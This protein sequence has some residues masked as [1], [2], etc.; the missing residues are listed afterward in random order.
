MIVESQ[1]SIN[2]WQLAHFPTATERGVV[3]HLT[4]EFREFL[5]A[6]GD[7]A[8]VEEAADIVI[9]LYCWAM[10]KGINLHE[11]IDKKMVKNRQ[12][13]WN[14]QPDGTGRHVRADKNT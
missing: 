6:D 10:L 8:A 14:I 2:R 1:E 7:M 3:G 11:A 12:R 4:E 13:Q 9:L 5:S